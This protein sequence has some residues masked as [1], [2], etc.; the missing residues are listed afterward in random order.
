MVLALRGEHDKAALELEKANKFD[1]TWWRRKQIEEAR[2]RSAMLAGDTQRALSL[3]EQ[4]LPQ[5]GFLTVSRLRLD[6][7][8]DPLRSNPRFQALLAKGERRPSPQ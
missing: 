5:P 4:F 2:A 1:N 3:L 7:V 8:Y 6:P